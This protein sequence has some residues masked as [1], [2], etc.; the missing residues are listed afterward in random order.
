MEGKR[1]TDPETD[2]TALD[3]RRQRP[4]KTKMTKI[5]AQPQK[6]IEENELRLPG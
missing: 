4:R 1:D 3:G 5:W 6:R 2:E